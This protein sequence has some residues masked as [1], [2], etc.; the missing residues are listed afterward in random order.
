MRQSRTGA[1]RPQAAAAVHQ[2]SSTA[3]HVGQR[4]G[5]CMHAH[6]PLPP[7]TLHLRRGIFLHGVRHRQQAVFRHHN[8]LLPCTA[9]LLHRL[10]GHAHHPLPIGKLAGARAVLGHHAHTCSRAVGPRECSVV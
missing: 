1:V 7:H 6:M 10:P 8:V 4:G 2:C 5:V 9:A 3:K